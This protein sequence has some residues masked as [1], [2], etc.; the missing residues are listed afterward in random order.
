[1][2]IYGRQFNLRQCAKLASV[3]GLASGPLLFAALK[4]GPLTAFEF[5]SRSLELFKDL[6]TA[7]TLPAVTLADL[8]VRN[9]HSKEIWID[10]DR[11]SLSMPPGELAL[12]CALV[13]WKDPTT[14]LEIGTYKGFTTLHLSK[15]TSQ[16]CRIFTVDLPPEAAAKKASQ[17]SDPHLIRESARSERAFGHDSK[18]AQILEDSTAIDWA[19]M[20]DRPVDFAFV[21]GSH[22]YEHVR[23]DTEA[24][25]KVLAAGGVLV[26]H[27]YLRVE[28]RRG[29]GR[30][31]A[32]LRK[33]GLPVYR[34]Q[35]TTLA[36]Y[37]HQPKDA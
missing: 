21:D 17:S 31:L 30:Y 18:I 33:T 25:F 6:A 22:L 15:N 32:E 16:D 3:V 36:I 29:V 20:V 24:V 27:D 2:N 34:L 13:R 12:L 11:P 5:A 14:V 1:M 10:L 8:G 4:K 9:V 23:K 37:V 7:D 19:R 28:V 26:W 35:G